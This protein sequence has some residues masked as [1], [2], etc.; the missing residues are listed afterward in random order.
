M[1]AGRARHACTII[2]S[3]A[4]CTA[5]TRKENV[6]REERRAMSSEECARTPHAWRE[7]NTDGLMLDADR[8]ERRM[9]CANMTPRF[10]S[11]RAE[12]PAKPLIPQVDR[13]AA[14]K[15]ECAECRDCWQRAKRRKKTRPRHRPRHTNGRR[16]VTIAYV[17]SDDSLLIANIYIILSQQNSPNSDHPSVPPPRWIPGTDIRS[18]SRRDDMTHDFTSPHA[19]RKIPDDTTT[20][21]HT[22]DATVPNDEKQNACEAVREERRGVRSVAQKIC[23]AR[24]KRV[25]QYEQPYAC[26]CAKEYAMQMRFTPR[27]PRCYF[28]ARYAGGAARGARVR[29][30]GGDRCYAMRRARTIRDVGASSRENPRRLPTNM[31][32]VIIHAPRARRSVAAEQSAARCALPATRHRDAHAPCYYCW[33]FSLAITPARHYCLSEEH[34]I[35]RHI[36]S[37]PMA[38]STSVATPAHYSDAISATPV[39]RFRRSFFFAR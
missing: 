12:E 35:S 23:S 32:F 37:E 29:W 6:R 21:T 34:A 24:W 36:F 28:T 19:Q 26:L 30:S 33:R 11:E 13:H 14:A 16:F 1:N 9:A 5:G 20:Y 4:S 2:T 7:R 22:P 25:T 3:P 39:C 18:D 8:G 10:Q 27:S 31:L 15:S 17:K 38:L